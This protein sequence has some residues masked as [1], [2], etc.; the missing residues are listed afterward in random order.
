M[1]LKR[2]KYFFTRIKPVCTVRHRSQLIVKQEKLLTHQHSLF[3]CFCLHS[4]CQIFI[5]FCV[6][7]CQRISNDLLNVFSE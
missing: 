6:A 7:A 1:T 4:Q 3:I 2:L 5:Q